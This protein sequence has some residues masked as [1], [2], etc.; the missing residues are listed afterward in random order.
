MLQVTAREGKL[1]GPTHMV[2]FVKTKSYKTDVMFENKNMSME[3]D[4]GSGVTLLSQTDLKP[5]NLI[6]KSYTG[7][8]IQCLGEKVMKTNINNQEANA[9]IRVVEGNGPSLLGRDL[10]IC[11]K[12]PWNDIFKVTCTEYKE[13]L[14]KYPDI[15]DES[16]VCLDVEDKNLIFRKARPVPYAIRDK[17][18]KALNKLESDGIME[19]VEFSEWASPVVPVLK[20]DGEIRICG[21]YSSTINKQ[22]ESDV[23]PLPTLEDVISKIGN[24]E[25]FTKLDLKQAFHQFELTKGSRKYTTINTTKGLYQY[26]RLVFGIPPATGATGD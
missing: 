26:N 18:Q 3:I 23:Y 11:F 7:N 6:L 25:C 24:G 1:E 4:T 12:L 20:S 2:N 16:S 10:L 21:G 8:Q 5:S 9:T 13:I 22:I 14:Q 19:K 15:F 17:Y